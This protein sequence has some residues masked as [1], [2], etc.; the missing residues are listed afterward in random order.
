M[1]SLQRTEC[2][3]AREVSPR[4]LSY[5]CDFF[6]FKHSCQ[7]GIVAKTVIDSRAETNVLLLTID[8]MVVNSGRRTG[9]DVVD[10][11]NVTA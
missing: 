3:L 11:V 2:H 7:G 6:T 9:K 4:G 5:E 1:G 10:G 8:V